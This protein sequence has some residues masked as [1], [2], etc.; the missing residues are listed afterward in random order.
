MLD[1]E[2]DT[3][4]AL[5]ELGTIGGLA[6]KGTFKPPPPEEGFGLVAAVPDEDDDEVQG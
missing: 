4:G 5:P 2:E 3:D 6:V 1:A